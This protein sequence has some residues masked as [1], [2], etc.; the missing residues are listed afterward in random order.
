MGDKCRGVAARIAAEFGVSRATVSYALNG[1]PGVSDQL[2]EQILAAA[3]RY[4]LPMLGGINTTDA[5][6]L[7]MILADVGNRF[8]SELA[9]SASDAARRSNAEVIL[10]HTDDEESAIQSA[11]KTM[12][13][14]GV[15]GLILTVARANDA[16]LMPLLR[17]AG[18]SCVQVS[19]KS[20][21][22]NGAFVGVDDYSAG[23]EVMEHILDHGY[24]DICIAV[25][26]HTSS[27][28]AQRARGMKDAAANRGVQIRTDRFLRTRL[29]AE[30]GHAAARYL[31][32]HGDLPEAVVCGADAIALGLISSLAEAGI[33]CPDDIAVTGYDGLVSSASRLV[34]LTT[35]AQPRGEMAC[36]AI[37]LLLNPDPTRKTNE[38][39]ICAHSL[40][41][42]RTCGCTGR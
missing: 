27:S 23:Y 31:L 34:G 15:S 21:Y 25:G 3:R 22:F 28:S 16:S 42:G 2:R 8:Y 9:V 41:I 39:I 5:V 19:R 33:G 35:I 20:Q 12:L 6:L 37:D 1:K 11:V 17:S 29:S 40:M 7:G 36:K 38:D 18:V 24:R 26:P 30:G 4:E 10:S 13:G 14:H 32:E